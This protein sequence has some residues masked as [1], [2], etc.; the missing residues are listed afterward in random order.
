MG[1]QFFPNIELTDDIYYAAQP[2][3]IQALRQMTTGDARTKRC[4]DL[5]TKGFLIHVP[6]MVWGWDPTTYMGMMEQDGLT[7]AA[8]A[9]MPPG[10]GSGPVP[11]GAIKISTK[12]KDYPAFDPPPPPEP[13]GGPLVGGNVFGGDLYT[14]GKG[15]VLNGKVQVLDGQVVP[16]DGA[17][18]K[19]HLSW[20]GSAM[21]G[22]GAFTLYF[23]RIG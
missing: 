12:A 14:Y 10:D 13:T 15:A 1:N 11:P 20:S 17:Q 3:E 6:I 5:A 7:W 16:Q 8:S 2:H 19:A 21:V 4:Q 18:Y 22:G 23:Q 9:L